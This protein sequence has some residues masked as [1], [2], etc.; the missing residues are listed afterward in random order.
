PVFYFGEVQYHVDES[1]GYV[2][3]KVWRT[4]TDLSKTGTVTVRSRKVERASAEAGVDYVGI[5]HILDFAPGVSM[6]TFKVTILDDMGQP[7]L[8]GAESF[9]LVLR[10]PVNGILGEPRKATVFINDSQSDLP[11]VHFREPV[12]SGEESDGQI[13]ATV[14]RSGD[15]WHKSSVRC[16]S[17]QGTAQVASDFEERPNTDASIITFS[18]GEVEKPCILSLVDDALYEEVEELRLVLGTPKSSSQFGAS[19]GSLNE[20][21]L[22]IKDTADKPIIRFAETKFNINEPKETGTVATVKIPVVRVGDTSKVSVVR[23][24][25]KDGSA[26]SGMDY[27]PVSQGELY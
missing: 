8:E 15:I 12:Y 21:L 5:S 24:H 20:A 7:E 1:D 22:K 27:Y 2:E 19:V 23:V 4:G 17:R 6:Q 13:T 25:T 26:V 11:K 18:P 14:Y 9:E 16:Y 10:M 3:V